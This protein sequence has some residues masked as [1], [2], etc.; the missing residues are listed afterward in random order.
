MDS[1]II[2]MAGSG[3]R[4]GLKTNK[5][6]FMLDGIPLFMHSVKTFLECALHIVLVIKKDDE[7]VVKEY[8]KD[9]ENVEY[10]FG[11]KTRQESVY[12]GLMK[13]PD[14]YI[15]IHDG[16]RPYIKRETVLEI[17]SKKERRPLLC[18]THVIDTIK[19]YDKNRLTTLDRN[20]LVAA[21]TPQCA[22]RQLFL[23]CHVRAMVDGLTF[24]DDISLI[25]HYTNSEIDI[26]FTNYNNKK[27]TTISDIE[28]LQKENTND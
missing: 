26:I 19:V 2:V 23:D 7:A 17:L 6:L 9:L 25:E 4:S 16:A 27:I 1:A 28:L 21:Q 5:N 13:A 20:K 3:V 14:G 12:N 10:V 11:G 22:T 8:I 18:A 15:L 24:S